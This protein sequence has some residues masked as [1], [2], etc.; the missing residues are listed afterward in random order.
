MLACAVIADCGGEPVLT[1]SGIFEIVATNCERRVPAIPSLD[2]CCNSFGTVTTTNIVI[3]REI[4]N[5]TLIQVP[6]PDRKPGCCVLHTQWIEEGRK[7]EP[8]VVLRKD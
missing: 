5:R 4:V 3:A 2:D 8:I 7:Y 6:C 1:N